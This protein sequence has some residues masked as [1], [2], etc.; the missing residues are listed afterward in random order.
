LG[1][2]GTGFGSGTLMASLRDYTNNSSNELGGIT[3]GSVQVVMSDSV[4]N[5]SSDCKSSKVEEGDCGAKK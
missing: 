4:V 1:A 3:G 2:S 5:Q